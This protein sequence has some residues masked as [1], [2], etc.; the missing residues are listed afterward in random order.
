M[1]MG[2]TMKAPFSKHLTGSLSMDRCWLYGM[3]MDSYKS[4]IL[5]GILMGSGTKTKLYKPV[6]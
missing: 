6:S 5:D 2:Q 3:G 1:D 4:Q